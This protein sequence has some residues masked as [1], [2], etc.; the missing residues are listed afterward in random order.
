MSVETY[1][2]KLKTIWQ[3]LTDYRPTITCACD[4]LK[5]F[6]DHLDLEYVMIFLMGLNE[7]YVVVQAQI[8]L[9]KLIPPINDVFALIIQE[10]HQRSAGILSLP[11]AP[12]DPIALLATDNSKRSSFADRSHKKEKSNQRPVCTHCG[13]KGHVIDRCYKLH[14]YPPGYKPRPV[15]PPNNSTSIAQPAVTNSVA[16]SNFFSSLTPSQ[17]SQLMEMLNSQLQAAKTE[18]ITVVSNVTHATGIYSLAS[19]SVDSLGDCWIVDSGA[20]KH[21]C[22]NRRLFH[23]WRCVDMISIILPT[24]YRVNVKH[25]GDIYISN[26]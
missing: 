4:G 3:D 20:S 18:L 15:T 17:C 10:E 12:T 11:T 13:I 7:L 19:P 8:L 22:H 14:G 9:M 2:T 24:S 1:Y 26:S 23:N 5:P 21:I 25:I 6:L 16:S